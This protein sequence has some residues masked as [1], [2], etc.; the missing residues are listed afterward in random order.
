MKILVADDDPVARFLTAGMLTRNGY[1]V[2]TVEN[3]R[4]AMQQ[5]SKADG[6]RL[7]LIDW[8]MP[9]QDGPSVCCEMR[10]RQ[11]DS[12]KYMLLL[13]SKQSNED[14]VR[15]LEAGADD[16]LRKPFDFAELKARL[17]TGRRILELEDRLVQAREEMRYEANHDSLT[18]LWNRGAILTL[19]RSELSRSERDNSAVSLLLCWSAR[20]FVPVRELV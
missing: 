20:Y 9:E 14:V 19:F 13:T 1:E 5:L 16:Y 15:G 3:G 10:E 12:Y 18:T 8:M 17:R 7:A 2:I 4:Q 6:P 11:G